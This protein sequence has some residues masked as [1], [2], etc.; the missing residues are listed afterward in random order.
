MDNMMKL[1]E[2]YSHQLEETVE[3]R[4]RQLEEEQKKT[5]ELLY[6]MLPKF[7]FFAK[8]SSYF[9]FCRVAYLHNLSDLTMRI[10]MLLFK[11]SSANFFYF[12]I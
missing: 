7:V 6:R 8:I 2:Q 3:I 10:S 4:K 5:E 12:K 9:I 1:M 11:T